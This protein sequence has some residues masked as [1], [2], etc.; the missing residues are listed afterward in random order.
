MNMK[1]TFYGGTETTTGSMHLLEVEQSKIL[2]D[3]GMYQGSRKKAYDIN[4]TFP[5]DPAKIETVLLS[6]AHIDHCGNLPNLH[7]QGYEEK[8]FCTHATR[9]LASVMLKDAAYIQ[10]KDSEFLHKHGKVAYGPLYDIMAA[11]KTIWHFASVNYHQ[12]FRIHQSA[13]VEFFDA[14]HILG[15]ALTKL[16]ATVDGKN[17][18]IVYAVDLGRKN[19]PI[20]R[21]PESVGSTDYLILESTYGGRQHTDINKAA[22]LLEGVINRTAKRG[23]K[24]IIPAFSLERTQEIVYVIRQLKAEKRIPALPVYID[25]PLAVNVTDI[26]R[27]HP[28]CFDFETNQLLERDEDPFGSGECTYVRSVDASKRLNTLPGPVIL[29]SASGMCE[30]GRILHHLANNCED[31]KNTILIVGYQAE[32]TLGRRMVEGAKKIKVFGDIYELNAQ[33]VELD[34]FSAHADEEDLIDFVAALN[35]KPK[36]TFLVHGEPEART[37]LQTALRE[38]ARVEAIMPAYGQ[39]FELTA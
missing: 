38:K 32:G 11:E 13:K 2:L 1:I 35:P 20:L 36:V 34:T 7:E 26:F 19:L 24:V 21:D 18:D 9:D 28:E 6:H 27:L 16:S 37:A 29:I 10:M 15:A 4:K 25:S 8:I 17:V 3:C 39:S 22:V 31:S 33:V 12:K 23:G 14:G 30:A 5:F